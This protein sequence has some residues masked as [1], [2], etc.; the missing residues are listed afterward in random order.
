MEALIIVGGMLGTI[1]MATFIFCLL[2][3]FE[4]TNVKFQ[5]LWSIPLAV[6]DAFKASLVVF[7]GLLVAI[8]CLIA[9]L[10][11]FFLSLYF[12]GFFN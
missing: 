4:S 3:S 10:A 5:P 2:L 7:W 11:P 6:F 1:Y 12:V 8:A 9:M